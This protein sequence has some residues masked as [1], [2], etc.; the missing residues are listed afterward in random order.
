MAGRKPKPDVERIAELNDEIE[1]L[2][3]KVAKYQTKLAQCKEERNRKLSHLIIGEMETRSLN[4]PDVE[5]LIDTLSRGEVS[6]KQKEA[7]SLPV[8]PVTSSPASSDSGYHFLQLEVTDKE[9][10]MIYSNMEKA[11]YKKF[12]EYAR[13]LLL[14]GYLIQWTSPET[15]ELRR[16]LGAVNRSLNQLV[17]RANTTGSIYAGDFLDMLGIWQSIQDKTLHYID[18]MSRKTNGLH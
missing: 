2:E 10:N 3:T 5:S 15:K 4:Y 17:K 18:E 9:R 11:H 13:K 8:P 6:E 7:A 12:S 1:R 14:D 16:E